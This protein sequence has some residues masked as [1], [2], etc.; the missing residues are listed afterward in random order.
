MHYLQKELYA[1]IKKDNTIFDF[2]QEAALDGMWYWDLEE[3]ENEWMSPRFW[4]V[5]GYDPK[6]KLH[7]VSQWQELIF[8]EDLDI[9]ISNF[10]KHCEDPNYPYDQ[11]VRYRHKTGK[12]IY[13][14]CRGIIIKN[15]QGKPT[16]MIGAHNDYTLIM[17]NKVKL[18]AILNSSLDGIMTFDSLRN[19]ANEIIDFIFT[20]SN[21][22]ACEII[23]YNEQELLGKRLSSIIPGNFMP[24]DSLNGNTLFNLYKEVVLLQHSETIEVYFDYD[25]ITEWFRIKAVPYQDGFMVTFAV[26][27]KEKELEAQEL[28]SSKGLMLEAVSHQWRQP[29]AEINSIVFK[30]EHLLNLEGLNQESFLNELK[31]IE[32][33][34]K[35]LSN[36]LEDFHENL[37]VDTKKEFFQLSMIIDSLLKLFELS[38]TKNS[39]E[40][41]KES[42]DPN[43]I[44]KSFPNHLTHVLFCIIQNAIEAFETKDSNKL[45]QI[46]YQVEGDYIKLS[47]K[48]NAGGIKDNILLKL[49]HSNISTKKEGKG[50]GLYLSNL[51][52]SKLLQGE[53][54][55]FNSLGGIQIDLKLKRDIDE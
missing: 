38:L 42:I 51:I 4:E 14:R 11:I 55:I 25:G 24:L 52:V 8:P 9:A 3:S 16:R 23:S 30:L 1:L 26:I 10:H 49:L 29:L 48:D 31:N 17:E 36:T 20:F 53:M 54:N 12:I 22:K 33:I 32:N 41:K 39:I 28:L 7:L 44:L 5:L 6:E 47:I 19:N 46:N 43:I 27:T 34:T 45:I 15:G 50:F 2:I 35:F 37:F 13:I 21:D 18:D 40:V